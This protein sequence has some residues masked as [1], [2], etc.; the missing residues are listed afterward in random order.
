MQLLDREQLSP[1][2]WRETFD[3]VRALEA[4]AL[5]QMRANTAD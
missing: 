1:D 5:E 4:A 2:D 3:A